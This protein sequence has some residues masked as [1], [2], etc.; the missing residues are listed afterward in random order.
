MRLGVVEKGFKVRA[1]R[2]TDQSERG[3]LSIIRQRWRIINMAIVAFSLKKEQGRYRLALEVSEQWFRG[4][5]RW[6]R[7]LVLGGLMMVAAIPP[8]FSYLIP[9]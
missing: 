5:F 4:C 9:V 6:M 3:A 7:R 2:Q 1:P 8:D